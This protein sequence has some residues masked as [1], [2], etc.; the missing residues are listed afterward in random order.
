M[1]CM[2][3][4]RCMTY[5]CPLEIGVCEVLGVSAGYTINDRAGIR[6]C[7]ALLRVSYVPQSIGLLPRVHLPGCI[8]LWA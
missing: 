2:T 4:M 3:C 8:C 1:T 5:M 6:A 7:I